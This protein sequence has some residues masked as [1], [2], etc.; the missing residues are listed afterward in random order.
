MEWEGELSPANRYDNFFGTWPPV[1]QADRAVTLL[2]R[3]LQLPPPDNVPGKRKF[4]GCF[5]WSQEYKSAIRFFSFFSCL[6]F[7]PSIFFR[8][9][10]VM[11]RHKI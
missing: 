9:R 4:K 11:P 5:A 2:E 8:K 7:A 10:W 3:G 6:P 1:N